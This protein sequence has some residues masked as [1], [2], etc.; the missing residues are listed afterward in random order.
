MADEQ[1]HLPEAGSR[2]S[3]G[4][5][6]VLAALVIGELPGELPLRDPDQPVEGQRPHPHDAVGSRGDESRSVRAEVQT[7]D[8]ELVAF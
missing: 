1:V 7:R 6:Q 8:E 2:T 3:L 5:V 4:P